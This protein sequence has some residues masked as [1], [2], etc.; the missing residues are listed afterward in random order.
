MGGSRSHTTTYDC[1]LDVE[2]GNMHLSKDPR[3]HNRQ[4]IISDAQERQNFNGGEIP[5]I[6]GSHPGDLQL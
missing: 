1:S 3:L 2:G 5:K 4:E 6:G